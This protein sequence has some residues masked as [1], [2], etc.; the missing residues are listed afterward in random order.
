MIVQKLRLQRG[1]SQDQL[2]R[3][4][5]LSTRTIQRIERGQAASLES[6]KSLAAVFEI[7]ITQLQ[8]EP[9]MN[10]ATATTANESTNLP[11]D[12]VRAL[13][14]VRKLKSFYMH[15]IQFCVVI[16]TLFIINYLTSPGYFW[17]WWVV[18]GW[19]LSLAWHGLVVFKGN[20]IFSPKWEKAQVEKQLGRKL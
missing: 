2:A 20:L 1:W 11:E 16:P 10:A 15:V 5:G 4:S 6:Q 14:H 17:A 12:E 7:N 8:Q 19:G 18:L 3:F 13:K 9:E